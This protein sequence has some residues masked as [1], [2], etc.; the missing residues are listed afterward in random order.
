M[1]AVKLFSIASLT[2]LHSIP[3]NAAVDAAATPIGGWQHGTT[4]NA[5]AGVRVVANTN[6]PA[7]SVG[8]GFTVICEGSFGS[9]EWQDGITREGANGATALLNVP[10][11][12][13]GYYSVPKFNTWVP[14]EAHVCEFKYKGHAKEGSYQISG[15]GFSFSLGF[16]Q[17]DQEVI[18]VGTIYFEM[19]RPGVDECLGAQFCCIP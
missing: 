13:P 19:I 7:L 8:G 3:S 14:G 1:N 6:K 10:F 5:A 9:I 11:N 2:L 17:G 18:K 12:P 4:S 16:G 15:A